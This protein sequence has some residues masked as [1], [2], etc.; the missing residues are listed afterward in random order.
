MAV[1]AVVF[2]LLAGEVVSLIMTEVAALFIAEEEEK[3]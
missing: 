3:N 1:L 2:V